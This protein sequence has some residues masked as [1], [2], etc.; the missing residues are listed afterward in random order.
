MYFLKR[1]ACSIPLL[2]VISFLAF[3]LCCASTPGG[4][5]DRERKPASPE[6]RAADRSEVSPRRTKV[7]T[8]RPLSRRPART[9]ILAPR[10]QAIATIP[11]TTSSR[12][13]CRCRMLLG[14]LAFGFAMGVGVPLGLFH[15]RAARPLGGLRR[16][17]FSRC[18]MV[19]VPGLVVAPLLIMVFAI[20][21]RLLPVALWASPLAGHSAD[22]RRWACYFS[23]THRAAHAR[24]NAAT[25]C[26]PNS[27][28]P[29][30]R[31][32]LDGKRPLLLKHAFRLAV[33]P[34]VSYSGPLLAD[35]LTGSFVIE[36]YFS[37]SRHRRVFREQLC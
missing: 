2:L 6:I 27:S 16:Q 32:D 4:P 37:N 20:K 36:N 10:T 15:R 34:V 25:R 14:V 28:R 17:R 7:E 8:I 12:R 35:L 26:N 11:S 31:R 33:L 1:L 21:W 30:A 23:G 24:R 18:L 13:R 29:R 22:R 5:F 19:C 3:M 9:A